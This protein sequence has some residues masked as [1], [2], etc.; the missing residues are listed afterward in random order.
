MT[1]E[2]NF[3]E[4]QSFCGNCGAVVEPGTRTCGVCGQPVMGPVIGQEAA[5]DSPPSDY[6]PYCR[7]CGVGV[8]WGAGYSCR[9]CGIE[10]LCALH[11]NASDSLCLDCARLPAYTD[12]AP[13]QGG[14]RCG[15]CG[16]SLAPDAD[17]CANCGRAVTA[18]PVTTASYASDAAPARAEYMGFWIRLAAF[19][20]DRIIVY[21]LAAI[22]AAAIGISRTSGEVD[23]NVQQDVTISLA[24]INY[25]FLLMVWGISVGYGVLFTA[26]RGQTLGKMLMRIQVVDANGRIP[27]LVP[28]YSPGV[29]GQGYFGDNFMAGVHLDWP[30]PEQTRLA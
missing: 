5:S 27:P 20:V 24:N 17:F 19:V 3:G 18:A 6:I 15:A 2:P 9:R 12:G 8:P 10:P 4:G 22:I 23:P 30:R 13:T 29:G 28:R 25:S 11:F 1:R 16:A 14:L 7:S 26:W 21:L